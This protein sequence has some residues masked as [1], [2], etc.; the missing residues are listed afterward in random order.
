M[1]K[2]PPAVSKMPVGP[3]ARRPS[4]GPAVF[5]LASALFAASC[6][7]SSSTS[8][9]PADGGGP[10]FTMVY[11]DVLSKACLPCHAPGNAGASAGRLDMSTQPTAYTSLQEKASG[12]SCSAG[13]ERVVPGD[14]AASLVVE[15]VESAH[16]SC[17]V[18]M[19]FGCA[20]TS[21]CLYAAQVQ[22]IKD[23]INDGA[24]NE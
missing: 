13:G 20:G 19:P 4:A 12:A 18:Q 6:G 22:E 5:A 15:K 3:D 1:K 24:T 7:A 16:P 9:S 8:P 10:T 2:A 11:A 14:A 21:T 23:W 17:G